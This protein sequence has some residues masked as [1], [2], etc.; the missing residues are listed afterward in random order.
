MNMN[1][2]KVDRMGFLSHE[3]KETLQR[4]LKE[5][6]M[7]IKR[8]EYSRKLTKFFM[9][10]NAEGLLNKLQ[11]IKAKEE[12]IPKLKRPMI[13]D[14]SFLSEEEKELLPKLLK[15]YGED[16]E[17]DNLMSDVQQYVNESNK[18]VGDI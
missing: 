1:E 14:L 5:Y 13:K 2:K 17:F 6:H 8:V 4:R 10:N 18:E 7:K 15:K 11:K 12:M 16:K 3:E 9:I